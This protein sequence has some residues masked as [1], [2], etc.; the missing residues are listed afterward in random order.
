M[1]ITIS[2]P[3]GSGKTTVARIVSERTGYRLISAGSL[4]REM[5]EKMGMNLIDFSKYAEEHHEIDREI[6]SKILEIAK[7][8][9]DLV[10]DSRLAG[11]M[12]HLN[13]IMA[14]KVFL[15]APPHIRARRIME[16]DGGE[17]D[18]VLK[19]MMVRE[20]SERRRYREIYGIDVEDKSI[21]DLVID[22]STKAPEEI[23][24]IILEAV[25]WK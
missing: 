24:L 11:W 7:N 19:N 14:F 17:L 22:T 2:G 21:Y 10:I 5:A 8:W 15:D 9:D 4:F 18:V 20:E 3:P 13:G 16:R 12:L 25:G 6:D 23:S 1:R